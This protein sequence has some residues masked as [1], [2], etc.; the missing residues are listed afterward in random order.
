LTGLSNFKAVQP[1]HFPRFADIDENNSVRKDAS[2]KRLIKLTGI[3]VT[4]AAACI[5][6]LGLLLGSFKIPSYA[7]WSANRKLAAEA[8]KSHETYR[9][10][11]TA[12]YNTA[13][14]ALLEDIRRNDQLSAK[15]VKPNNM[16]AEDAMLDY[17][18]LAV[19]SERNNHPG[20]H[21]Y[22]Q[23]A[24][25]RCSK[26]QWHFSCSESYLRSEVERTDKL[27]Y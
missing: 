8:A 5:F 9:L 14:N 24:L 21:E 1:K 13:K 16:F 20:G 26:L 10:Y 18:R 25:V 12:D 23:E 7:A 4:S 3:S 6:A 27:N 2:M 19:L 22:M 15:C 17:A 11:R